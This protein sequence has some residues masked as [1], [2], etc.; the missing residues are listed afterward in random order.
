MTQ[1]TR[2][3]QLSRTLDAPR[4]QVFR[5]WTDPEKI[6]QWWGPIG[7]ATPTAEIGR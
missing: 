5:A 6:K 7:S 2:E 1:Q 4:E 3:L